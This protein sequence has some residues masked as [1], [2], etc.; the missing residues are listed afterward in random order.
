MIRLVRMVSFLVVGLLAIPTLAVAEVERIE[1]S[2][3][4]VFADGMEFGQVGA[5]EKIR[6]KLFYAV[7]PD[8]PANAAIVDLELAPRGADGKVRFQG[9]FILLKPVDLAK[10]NGRLLYDVNNRGNLYMLRHINGGNRTNDPS[11]A[12]D[13][14]NGF[15]MRQ[16]YSLLWSAW[17]WDV[18][19]GNHRLQIELPIATENGQTIRQRI[20]AE[21]VNSYG[22]TAPASMPLAWGNSRCYP[23]LDA[24]DNSDS[25]LTLRGVPDGARV[26]I[27]NDRW[28]FSRVEDGVR[29]PDPTSLAI[30][31]GI[32]PGFIYELIYEVENPRV[33]G[34]G[35]AAVRDAISFFH[36]EGADRFGTP[37]PLAIRAEGGWISA[38]DFAYVFGVSQSGRFIVHMLWQGFHVDESERM[39][40]EGARIHVAGGGKGGFNHRFAQTTHHPSDFEGNFMPADHPPFN[41]LPDGSPPGNDVLVEAKR[42]GALPKIIMTNNTLEYWTRSASLVHTDPTGTGDAPFHPNIRYFMTNG[43]PHG[44]AASRTPTVTEHERNPLGVED[45]QRAMVVNLDRWVSEGVDPPPSRY[46]RFDRGELITAAEHGEH[47]PKIPGMRHPGRNLQPA[48][49]DYGPD[50][51][52]G[53]VFTIVPPRVGERYRSLVPAFDA[54]GNGLGGI[55][56]P[57]LEAPLG[58]YQGW[59]PRAKE[60]GSPDYL[61][62]FDGSFWAFEITDLERETAGD[63]RPSVEARYANREEYAAM[64]AKAARRLVADRILL[65]EDGEAYLDIAGRM[66]WPPEP[67][68]SDPFWR[69][70]PV[71]D[72]VD[73][74]VAVPTS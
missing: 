73:M 54:D 24:G 7:D 45:V 27:P 10:G 60:F 16:G 3:R 20:A 69:L 62:R 51:W 21:I 56:L 41:F 23:A 74:P 1:I 63:P 29:V 13:A 19:A 9:D 17:N 8:N 43:A 26:P 5:Y 22:L 11:S 6:G 37:S 39:V 32:Q 4:S 15:L 55:R 50:F 49:V 42:L 14:G 58:T 61:T 38:I 66:A 52:T 53:G 30:E 12:Q 31:G 47:F 48:R 68:D 25:V 70:E 44:G 33:V 34:L 28:S 46:P 57:E 59:N 40:F 71:I 35:L 67:I 18:R 2:S 72:T 65:K 64:V 36:F